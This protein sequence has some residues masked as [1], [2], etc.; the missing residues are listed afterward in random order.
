[1]FHILWILLVVLYVEYEVF[2]CFYLGLILHSI[3]LTYSCRSNMTFL[4]IGEF[5]IL[6]LLLLL[7]LFFLNS[8][9][10]FVTGVIVLLVIISIQEKSLFLVC[11][12][13]CDSVSYCGWETPSYWESSV[14]ICLGFYLLKSFLF[15]WVFFFG[16]DIYSFVFYINSEFLFSLVFP[17]LLWD[18]K[19]DLGSEHMFDL[20]LVKGSGHR[21]SKSMDKSGIWVFFVLTFFFWSSVRLSI[22]VL[23]FF[24]KP[25]FSPGSGLS[26]HPFIAT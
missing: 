26:F 7:W 25:G 10:L 15:V 14:S 21:K 13:F 9:C 1:M 19:V 5:F 3:K 22:I 18:S 12:S 23:F 17:A 8:H 11:I 24:N 4:S 20:C 6:H 16:W 2:L